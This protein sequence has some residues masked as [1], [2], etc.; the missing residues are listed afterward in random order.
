[1]G[2]SLHD[3]PDEVT[4]GGGWE[5]GPVRV[6]DTVR[7]RTG[8]WTPAVHALLRHLEAVGFNAA[9]K[10][11]GVDGQGREVVTYIESESGVY[12]LPERLP[13]APEYSTR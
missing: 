3:E 13:S 7:R 11:L 6:G 12:P 9:P 8:R 5:G 1:M 2:G 4:L 10:V